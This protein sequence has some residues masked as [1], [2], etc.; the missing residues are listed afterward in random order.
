MVVVGD[1]GGNNED[2]GTLYVSMFHEFFQRQFEL[3]G[4]EDLMFYPPKKERMSVVFFSCMTAAFFN[5][6]YDR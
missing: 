1:G 3:C 5:G 2:H 4:K 6:C